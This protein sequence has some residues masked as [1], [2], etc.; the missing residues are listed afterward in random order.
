[1]E[2]IVLEENLETILNLM[3][4]PDKGRAVPIGAA[5]WD[6]TSAVVICV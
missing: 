5:L 2:I 3:I 6:Q 1:M 4:Y